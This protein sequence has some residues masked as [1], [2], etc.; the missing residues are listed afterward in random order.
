MADILIFS[1][2]HSA[3]ATRVA[4]AGWAASARPHVD[5]VRHPPLMP[6][7]RRSY[8]AMKVSPMESGAERA[9]NGW[10]N[11]KK[12]RRSAASRSGSKIHPGH[13]R[14]RAAMPH[15]HCMVCAE[16]HILCLIPSLLAPVDG[17]KWP[18]RAP[19]GMETLVKIAVSET[20]TVKKAGL[21]E[22]ERPVAKEI[23]HELLVLASDAVD[24]RELTSAVFPESGRG[25]LKLQAISS[26]SRT[27]WPE[28]S[29]G[30]STTT[31]ASLKPR[32]AQDWQAPRHA[33]ADSA[34]CT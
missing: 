6:F 26:C 18:T 21:L 1:T 22:N 33:G 11:L 13:V 12:P 20:M 32:R 5:M 19:G 15:Q 14:C 17:D 10:R 34:R 23:T 29:V 2:L 28:L 16:C 8:L 31:A 24:A 4:Q 25:N 27:W 7:L 9:Q 30:G 3:T